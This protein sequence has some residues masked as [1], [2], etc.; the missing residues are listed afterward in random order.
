MSAGTAQ[1][2]KNISVYHDILM[3]DLIFAHES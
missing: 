1:K 2:F 3:I